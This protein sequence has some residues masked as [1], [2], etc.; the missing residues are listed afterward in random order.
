MPI[1]MHHLMH[2]LHVN[3][4]H[5]MHRLLFSSDV[6]IESIGIMFSNNHLCRNLLTYLPYPKSCTLPIL[7]F[8]KSFSLF[9]FSIPSRQSSTKFRYTDLI[10]IIGSSAAAAAQQQQ[11]QWSVIVHHLFTTMQC[12]T[13]LLSCMIEILEIDAVNWWIGTMLEGAKILRRYQRY[14]RC[15]LN[16]I[17]R[18]KRMRESSGRY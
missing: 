12:W 7:D 3:A 15:N 9:F 14:H 10:W 17:W 2:S 18:K 13:I 6:M 16:W 5:L 11:Q 1:L 4:F 8:S